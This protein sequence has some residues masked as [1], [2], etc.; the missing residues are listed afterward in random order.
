MDYTKLTIDQVRSEL[1][2]TAADVR[3][4]F[5][6]FDVRQLNWRPAAAAWSVAQC[7]EHLARSNREMCRAISQ[8]SDPSHP[9]TVWQRLPLL[10]RLFGR[11]LIT[12][13]APAGT[14]K[15]TAP[16]AATPSASEIDARVIER[17][18]DGQ[19]EVSALARSLAGRDLA[20]TI[21]GSPFKSFVT[22]S[23]LDGFRLIAA[24]E[25][26]HYEQARRV[27]AASGFPK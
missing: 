8:A 1:D 22:Y 14:R 10:P 15:F 17:F 13:Q 18:V 24:H 20:R 27:R 11:L 25:R 6:R 21:M 23:V 7:L 19:H 4:A 12:T 5:G 16:Q 9:R 2:K 3:A 26:R